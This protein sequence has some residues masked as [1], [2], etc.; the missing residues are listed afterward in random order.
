M[1]NNYEKRINELEAKNTF[2]EDAIERLSAEVRKQQQ[3]IISLKDK[4]LAVINT[5]D[6]NALS[7]NSEEKPP[8]Y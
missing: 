4:L 2:Q 3:E 1:E 7:E 5:L 8:H 6:K